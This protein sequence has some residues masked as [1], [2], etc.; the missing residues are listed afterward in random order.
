MAKNKKYQIQQ[1]KNK[2]DKN[3]CTIEG[4]YISSLAGISQSDRAEKYVLDRRG[5]GIHENK[6]RKNL[7]KPKH[8]NSRDYSNSCVYFL[9]IV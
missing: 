6:K 7:L 5:S 8:K 2:K 3:K 4:G 1:K 9:A